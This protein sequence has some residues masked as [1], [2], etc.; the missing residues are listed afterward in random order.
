MPSLFYLLIRTCV[1]KGA[2]IMIAEQ[3]ENN[4]AA[5]TIGRGQVRSE[6]FNRSSIRNSHHDRGIA[7]TVDI[8]SLIFNI[9]RHLNQGYARLRGAAKELVDVLD[10]DRI[11]TGTANGNLQLMILRSDEV[12]V[13]LLDL[14]SRHGDVPNLAAVLG[15][16]E[17]GS[18]V[19]HSFDSRDTPH[20]LIVGGKDAGKTVMLRSVAASL[21]INNR[22]SEIQLAVI[23]PVIANNERQRSQSASWLPLN[24]LPHM[25]CDVAF[26]HSEI[27]DLLTFL[28]QEISYREK[29]SFI[30]PRMIVLID[31]ADILVSRGGR[32]CS[33]PLLRLAQKGEDVGIHLVLSTQ[34]FDSATFSTQLMKEIPTRLIGRSASGQTNRDFPIQHEN[35]AEQLLGEGDFLHRQ[36]EHIRRF[37]GA[38]IDDYDLHLKLTEMYRR[39]AILL[40]ETFEARLH[41]KQSSQASAVVLPSSN[42]D[43]VAAVVG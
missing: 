23:S 37:Q 21:A 43:Q 41:L 32:Q 25:I 22:Q 26:R 1:L 5:S 18:M 9:C 39:R 3:E 27:I 8:D 7:G 17:D 15:L 36:G 19:L 4:L 13:P 28:N 38:Y 30:E 10:V 40:A 33:E 12:A 20:L 35:S 11:R 34:S 42:I 16:A 14:M 6:E 24:Y 29:H 2:N 31:Q